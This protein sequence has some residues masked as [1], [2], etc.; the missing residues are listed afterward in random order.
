M[1]PVLGAVKTGL[2][3]SGDLPCSSCSCRSKVNDG[4]SG[5]RSEMNPKMVGGVKTGLS[6]SRDLP[7][8]IVGGAT[9]LDRLAALPGSRN[10][11][12]RGEDGGESCE[13]VGKQPSGLLIASPGVAILGNYLEQIIF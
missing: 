13:A 8:D 3:W 11:S 6:W 1:G 12:L 4:G 9:N 5:C 7:L 2:N 10:L